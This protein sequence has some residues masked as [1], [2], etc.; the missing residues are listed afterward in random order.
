MFKGVQLSTKFWIG[1]VF[2]ILSLVLGKITQA[3]FIIFFSDAILRWISI[4]VYII[5][6]PMLI[7]GV[8]WVGKEYAQAITKYFS[9]RFYGQK[10]KAGV[11]RLHE[12][13]KQK[14]KLKK[15]NKLKKD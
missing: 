8:W 11:I 13:S 9:Y 7:I 2:I 1:T 12:K 3:V 10:A 15:E 4:I 6:W 5:S 14:R